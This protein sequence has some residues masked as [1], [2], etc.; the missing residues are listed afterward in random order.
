MKAF[1]KNFSISE[2]GRYTNIDMWFLTKLFNI[3]SVGSDVKNYN[4][5]SINSDLL[6]KS[7]IFG[8]SDLQLSMLLDS[9]EYMVR[10]MRLKYNI[11]P[12]VKQIDTTAGEFP[13]ETNYLYLTYSGN[14]HDIEFDTNG[15]IVLGC[16]A[17]RIGS[18]VE[19]DWCAVNCLNTLKKCNKSSIMINYN[20]ETVSTDYDMSDRLYFEEITLERVLDIYQLEQPEGVVVSLGGQVPNNIAMDLYKNNVRILGTSPKSIDSAETRRKYCYIFLSGIFI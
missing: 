4:L 10:N 7:K 20:P 5:N 12:F 14:S 11:K 9:N 16:G 13:A 19:F 6:R 17:Y 15:V 8:Y 2:I 18:S 3:Y 1:S